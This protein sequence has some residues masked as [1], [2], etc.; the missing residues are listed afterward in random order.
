MS[1]NANWSADSRPFSDMNPR[2]RKKLESRFL[3][4]NPEERVILETL[5]QDHANS[6]STISRSVEGAID[7]H[8]YLATI[9]ALENEC[10][11]S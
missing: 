8:A 6:V 3:A 7:I 11:R 9:E 5:L 10:R 4:F 1:M 2:P